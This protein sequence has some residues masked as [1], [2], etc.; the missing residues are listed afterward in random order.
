MFTDESRVFLGVLTR[1]IES[2]LP[3]ATIFRRMKEQIDFLSET[4]GFLKFNL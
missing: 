2:T 3:L 4:L 1:P